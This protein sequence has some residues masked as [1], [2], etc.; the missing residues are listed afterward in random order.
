MHKVTVGYRI[1]VVCHQF[2]HAAAV[3]ITTH[4][5][6]SQAFSTYWTAAVGF[7]PESFILALGPNV[8]SP[9]LRCAAALRLTL[10]TI[11]FSAWSDQDWWSRHSSIKLAAAY[12][13][14][15]V[16]RC[17]AH[18]TFSYASRDFDHSNNLNR[19]FINLM[20]ITA[21]CYCQVF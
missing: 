19:F 20:T 10:H 14:K 3:C 11:Y 16:Q 1:N 15:P 17:L 5:C 9:G 21:H 12:G 13:G 2:L 6:M 8:L 7:V 4:D 18:V